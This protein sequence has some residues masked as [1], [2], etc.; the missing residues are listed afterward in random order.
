MAGHVMYSGDGKGGWWRTEWAVQCPEKVFFRNKCQGVLGHKGV[1]WAFGE[2]GSFH[3][4]DNDSDPQEDGACGST[5]PDHKSYKTPMAM[6][7]HYYMSHKKTAKVRDKAII[8]K[9]E[10]DKI[11]E[12]DASINAPVKWDKL[13]PALRKKLMGRLKSIPKE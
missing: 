13:D 3:W 1:H 11:P 12:K 7:K 6:Q 2:D 8:A 4:D 5:P 9:L 10:Q